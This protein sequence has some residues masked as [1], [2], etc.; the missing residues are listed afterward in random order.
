[1]AWWWEGT[2]PK[3]PKLEPLDSMV[4]NGDRSGSNSSEQ[5]GLK[6]NDIWD[7]SATCLPFGY[8]VGRY[9]IVL[10]VQIRTPYAG[11]CSMANPN[12]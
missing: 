9:E 6:M 10:Q 2:I 7:S 1:M 5:N 4:S 11:N 12:Q 8:S 3:P